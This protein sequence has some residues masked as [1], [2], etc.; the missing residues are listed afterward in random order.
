M[1]TLTPENEAGAL[2]FKEQIISDLPYFFSTLNNNLSLQEKI[3]L[4][5]EFSV[6]IKKIFDREVEKPISLFEDGNSHESR[7]S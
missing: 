7:I 4:A 2:F 5:D 3:K 6:W 1:K